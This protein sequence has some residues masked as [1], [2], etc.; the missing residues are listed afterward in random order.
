MSRDI[1]TIDS[2]LRLL[3]DCP[4]NVTGNIGPHRP[5]SAP[6]TCSMNAMRSPL[7]TN[8]MCAQDGVHA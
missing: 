6:T 7:V 2:E 3:A 8:L 5:A 4:T 1:R